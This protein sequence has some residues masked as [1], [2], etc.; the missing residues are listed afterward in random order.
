MRDQNRDAFTIIELLISLCI[1]AAIVCLLIPVIQGARASAASAACLSNL[2]QLH[3]CVELYAQANGG[4]IQRNGTTAETAAE[5]LLSMHRPW[6][7][8]MSPSF[9]ELDHAS[10][11]QA[12]S[13]FRALHCPATEFLTPGDF[14][15]NACVISNLYPEG[16]GAVAGP[17]K[18]AAVRYP[19]QVVLLIDM[20]N[21]RFASEDGRLV[22]TEMGQYTDSQLLSLLGTMDLFSLNMIATHPRPNVSRVV[23]ANRHGRG[24]V[25]V[26]RFDGSASTVAS[27][28][29]RPR[30]FDDGIEDMRNRY[31]FPV[32]SE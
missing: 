9:P 31:I 29:L 18:I 2:R 28:G 23:P 30:D 32:V 22:A 13:R 21:P 10:L 4:W 27:A 3:Q 25:N 1:I 5:P 24:K 6:G 7:I 26:V 17:T 12:M 8:M 19:S 14:A 11:A 20:V 15:M 16:G